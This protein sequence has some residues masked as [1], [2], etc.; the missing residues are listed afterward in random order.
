M[1]VLQRGRSP[2]FRPT[3]VFSWDQFAGAEAR[4][5]NCGG[6]YELEVGDPISVVPANPQ[7][8]FFNGGE[9]ALSPCP[10]C[11]HLL[12]FV[13]MWPSPKGWKPVVSPS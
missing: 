6:C 7:D 3:T 9:H 11:H 12:R 2:A 10:N 5:T 8:I 4:C 1:I 13:A